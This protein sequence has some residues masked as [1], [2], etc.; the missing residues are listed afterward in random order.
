MPTGIM[1]HGCPPGQ[2]RVKGKC[3]QRQYPEI[4]TSGEAGKYIER[5]IEKAIDDKRIPNVSEVALEDFDSHSGYLHVVIKGKHGEFQHFLPHPD[6]GH[7]QDFK[8]KSITT[9]LRRVIRDIKEMHPEIRVSVTDVPVKKY[10]TCLYEKSYE[11][12]SSDL[13]S[14]EYWI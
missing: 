6:K 12:Y 2:K 8:M 3:I 14:V 5:Q 7:V 13:I 9:P 11:G 1:P 10:S 4:T